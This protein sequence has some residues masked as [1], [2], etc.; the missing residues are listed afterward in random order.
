MTEVPPWAARLRAER[1]ERDWSQ[2][3]LAREL[4]KAI[5]GETRSRLPARESIIRNIKKWEAGEHQP[6]DPYRLLYCRVFGLEEAVLFGPAEPQDRNTVE[7]DTSTIDPTPY[8]PHHGPVAPELVMYFLEQLPGHYKADMWLGPRHLIPT[9]ATQAQLIKELAQVA[10]APVRRGLL[11]AGVA[12]AALL[13]WLYQDAGDFNLNRSRLWRSLALDMAHRSQDPQLISYALTNKAML[14]VDLEDGRTVVD[15]AEAALTGESKLCP[16]VRILAL[17][18]Q[19]HGHSMLPAQ[20]RDLVD[21][22]LD[23]AADLVDRVDDEHPWGNACRRTL[24]YIDV[25]RA[26]AYLRLG[27]YR[28]AIALWDRILGTAPESARRDN[29]VFW[30]RQASALAALPEPERVVQ[31]ASATASIVEGTGSVRLRQELKAIP[32]RATAWVGT[33][34]GRELTEIISQFA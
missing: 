20:N 24:G 5:G 23:Q 34:S 29:G 19:A 9:V 17:V 6:K 31:I 22:L 13:G 8:P 3:D 16:K 15:Y 7:T 18:H 21:R 28:E 2:R 12:Y 27:A 1:R 26:T 11:G 14:A 10:D 4:V 30:A 32:R 33:A 25:Q